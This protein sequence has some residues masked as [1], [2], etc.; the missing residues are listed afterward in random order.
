MT[1]FEIVIKE[2]YTPEGAEEGVN[3]F[4]AECND[5]GDLIMDISSFVVGNQDETAYTFIFK[6]KRDPREKAI[7]KVK[8]IWEN[9]RW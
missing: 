9:E 5:A 3:D 6:I 8:K 2:W 1:D 7:N 4:I